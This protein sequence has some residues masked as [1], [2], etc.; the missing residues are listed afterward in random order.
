MC[1]DMATTPMPARPGSAGA[2][3][4]QALTHERQA[5]ERHIRD[6]LAALGPGPALRLESDAVQACDDPTDGGP[7][8]RVFVARR[9]WLLGTDRS[10]FDTLARFWADHGYRI[11]EDRRGTAYPY[12]WVEHESDG[13]RV[14]IDANAVGDLLLGASSPCFWPTEEP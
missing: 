5:A 9:Y 12:L 6:A 4:P 3:P 2:G 13:F 7:P 8:G 10:A 11:V 1:I 14:G